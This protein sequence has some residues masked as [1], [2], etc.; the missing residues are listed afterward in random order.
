MSSGDVIPMIRASILMKLLSSYKKYSQQKEVE[1]F[2][3]IRMD[4]N[5]LNKRM[6]S[7]KLTQ[8]K[9]VSVLDIIE[10]LYLKRR[11]YER[12]NYSNSLPSLI[13]SLNKS[14]MQ[15]NGIYENHRENQHAL[16]LF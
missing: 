8:N 2:S 15:V 4:V 10:D 12:A 1:L 16:Y 6:E 5:I 9:L 14:L 11:Q 7:H 3:E 13:T